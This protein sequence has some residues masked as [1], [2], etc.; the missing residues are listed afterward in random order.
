MCR[1]G[2]PGV[3]SVLSTRCGKRVLVGSDDKA[4]GS[5]GPPKP[6][7]EGPRKP[8]Q[9]TGLEPEGNRGALDGFQVGE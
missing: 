6:G 2:A 1:D 7:D 5:N 9:G 8:Y 3:V 4:R